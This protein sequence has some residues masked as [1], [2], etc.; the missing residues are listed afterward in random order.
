MRYWAGV[1]VGP[2]FMN[3]S[4]RIN[5][6][7]LL[8]RCA[9]KAIFS[10]V[11]DKVPS[12]I[13]RI[14][15]VPTGK[16]GDVV[17]MTPVLAAIR[18]HLPNTFVTVFGNSKLH[19]P[20]LGDSG[21]ADDYLDLKEERVLARI[22]ECHADVALVTGHSYEATALFYLADIPLIVAPYALGGTSEEETRPYKILK[23]FVKNFPIKIGEYA[24]RERLRVLEPLGIFEE[25]TK[26]ILGFSDEARSEE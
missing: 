13:S 25:N 18:K 17:C 19:Q 3:F 14:I 16:L 15:V 12:N 9:I 2:F 5:R 26:K 10:G 8:T 22:K 23:R 21:L 4:G 20:L 6:I 7:L 1:R 24:P 11:A